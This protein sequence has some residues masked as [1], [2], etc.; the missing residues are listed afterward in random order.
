MLTK[1]DGSSALAAEI[2][3]AATLD[4][5]ALNATYTEETETSTKIALYAGDVVIPPVVNVVVIATGLTMN[6]IA[7]ITDNHHPSVLEITWD[8]NRGIV[9]LSP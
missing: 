2:E 7:V 4:A 5:T 1:K 6:A 8:M 3:S 9:S